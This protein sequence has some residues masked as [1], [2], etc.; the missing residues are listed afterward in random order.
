MPWVG[1]KVGGMQSAGDV[2]V[3]NEERMEMTFGQIQ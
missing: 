3:Q 1:G 2:G